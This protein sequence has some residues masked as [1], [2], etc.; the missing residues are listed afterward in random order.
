MVL[1]LIMRY[2]TVLLLGLGLPCA[3]TVVTGLLRIFSTDVHLDFLW[4]APQVSL[5]VIYSFNM[6]HLICE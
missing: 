4:L 6:P 5:Q 1:Y 2:G 3:S